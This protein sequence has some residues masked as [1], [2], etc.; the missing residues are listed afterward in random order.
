M[1]AERTP[2]DVFGE[3]LDL[4]QHQRSAYLERACAGH[5]DLRAEVEQLLVVHDES[6]KFLRD[7]TA[8][9]GPLADGAAIA[10]GLG[11]TV[12][13]YKLLQVIGEGG[14][15]IVY[16]AE[17]VEP[18]RRR[19]A[20]KIIKLGMDTK[21]VLARFEAER[22]ALALMDHPNIARVL[23]AGATESGRP[24]FV[25]EL[26]R[27]V[28]I[29][30]FCDTNEL[31]PRERL[32]LF[33]QVCSAV[34]NAH[35]KGVIHRD[36]KPSNILV[37][38]HDGE[39]VPKVIDF[40]I[41]KATNARL[42]ER[43]LFTQ[44]HQ[45]IG[46]PEYVSPEQ[47]EMSGLD[48]D[49]RSDVYSL[50]VLLYELLTGV[51]PLDAATLRQAG[52]TE[53]YRMIRDCEPAKPSTRVSTFGKESLT[54]VAKRRRMEPT[55][56]SSAIRGE[57]DWIVMRALE[58]D[59]RRR[60]ESASALAHDVR[61]HLR[62]DAVLAS[63]PS[64]IYRFKKLVRRN[65]VAFAAAGAIALAMSAGLAA[66]AYGMVQAQ[67]GR[68]DEAKGHAEA[69]VAR[70]AEAKAR[71][72]A[73]EEA[74]N[75]RAVTE[76]LRKMLALIDPTIAPK[77]RLGGEKAWD[78]PSRAATL[79]AL[80]AAPD[81]RPGELKV[82]EL[83]RRVIP[84]IPTATAGRPLVEAEIRMIIGQG[85]M[86]ISWQDG[87]TQMMDGASIYERTL[88]AEHPTALR[89]FVQARDTPTTAIDELEERLP[90]VVKVLGPNDPDTLR[91]RV[92]AAY[93][94][95]FA[96]A[97]PSAVAEARAVVADT[98]RML[99][100]GDP[101]TFRAHMALADRLALEDEPEESRL[102]LRRALDDL[103]QGAL[104]DGA[105]LEG[106][107][108][109]TDVLYELGDV[110]EA[111]ASARQVYDDYCSIYG[112][113]GV[114]AQ[115]VRRDLITMLDIENRPDEIRA[116][117]AEFGHSMY[118]AGAKV[119][120]RD[121]AWQAATMADF[122]DIDGA[123]TI[124][125]RTIRD[126]ASAQ[127][128]PAD[129]RE[130]AATLSI[131]GHYVL[132][133][134]SRRALAARLLP[135]AVEL[136]EQA[137]QEH[138][139]DHPLRRSLTYLRGV[140]LR[141][142]GRYDEARSLWSDQLEALIETLGWQAEPA[143]SAFV[144]LL[145]AIEAR[146]AAPQDIA[147]VNGILERAGRELANQPERLLR[148]RSQA[149]VR[150]AREAARYPDIRQWAQRSHELATL[151]FADDLAAARGYLDAVALVWMHS[152]DLAAALPLQQRLVATLAERPDSRNIG[153]GAV[154]H[155]HLGLILA[156]AGRHNEALAHL[157]PACRLIRRRYEPTIGDY[158]NY[159]QSRGHFEALAD[160][161]DTLGQHDQVKRWRA[162]VR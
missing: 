48:V 112:S 28:P 156:A 31:S 153:E 90:V 53:I 110:E 1:T 39:P 91:A 54:T 98:E 107:R 128:M 38:L 143:F 138:S 95:W 124:L 87:F 88:G 43:T 74:A 118:V 115:V 106:R 86:C 117:S 35:E 56:L 119:G 65:K 130:Q 129:V 11:A 55:K 16:M 148:W 97:R 145:T 140:T 37:T 162:V 72:H 15:G 22:Q 62:G 73:E 7:P 113:D 109:V 33:A 120:P 93:T 127:G 150:L 57:L 160:L 51:T 96:T 159:R 12:G 47:A 147:Q 146:P 137:V 89:A 103:P 19:V 125:E 111:I 45:F 14:F 135:T 29:T 67:N 13:R 6:G 122:G 132:S 40:G 161:L 63:P 151:H 27:G 23:D 121:L 17:Q 78:D 116:V 85:L 46:T 99:G 34:Q 141:T 41:A 82:A 142:L 25:M 114:G 5:P 3:A 80:A 20:L 100:P 157:L 75:A 155:A 26:V 58:K 70:D 64:R 81:A 126:A 24:Y 30:E 108:S 18:I 158:D 104:H 76:F 21:Q 50:G 77:D 49:T 101:L 60:Y 123:S 133:R 152:G 79:D 69:L 59:R 102:V 139:P 9:E 10:E 131:I 149:A 66:S 71:A 134:P 2:M 68:R 94:G 83:L 136:H 8:D 61:R 44:F 84:E 4:A 42:T 32:E 92:R 52:F 36:L 144:N 154:L 105:Y